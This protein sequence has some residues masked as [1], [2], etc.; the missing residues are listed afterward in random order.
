[1]DRHW[2]SHSGAARNRAEPKACD[3][4]RARFLETRIAE[5]NGLE[6]AADIVEK[7]LGLTV[8]NGFSKPMLF[9]SCPRAARQIQRFSRLSPDITEGP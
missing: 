1:M 9:H 5:A 2:Q 3:L 4:P 7:A 8:S 6:R